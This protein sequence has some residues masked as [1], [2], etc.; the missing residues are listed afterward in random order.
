MEDKKEL[1]NKELE[2]VSGGANKDLEQQIEDALN[3][4]VVPNIFKTVVATVPFAL[5]E[6]T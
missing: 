4:V 1:N 6:E 5:Y 3:E 2:K